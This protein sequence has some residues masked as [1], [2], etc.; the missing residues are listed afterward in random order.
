[1]HKPD[2]LA[3]QLQADQGQIP[4]DSTI[5]VRSEDRCPWGVGVRWVG[6][7]MPCST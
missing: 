7:R 1:V 2:G 5:A 6:S 4:D 3:A